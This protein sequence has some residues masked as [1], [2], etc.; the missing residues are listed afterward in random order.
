MLLNKLFLYHLNNFGI[1]NNYGLIILILHKE[2]E[3]IEL[4]KKLMV[5]QLFKEL[6]LLISKFMQNNFNMEF[7]CSYFWDFCYFFENEK[8]GVISFNL[9]FKN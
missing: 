6:L 1:S 7:S 3:I 4:Y 9:K 2:M 5:E 8:K